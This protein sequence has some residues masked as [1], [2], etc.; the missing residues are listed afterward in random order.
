MSLKHIQEKMQ[1]LNAFAKQV[2]LNISSKKT[3]IMALNITNTR[4]IQID[5]EELPYTRQIY[6]S[7]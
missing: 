7:R 1:R 2:G 5:N 3:E 6:L 4:P